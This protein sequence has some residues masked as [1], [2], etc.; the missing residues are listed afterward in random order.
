MIDLGSI[1][2]SSSFISAKTGLAPAYTTALAVAT[3]VILGTITS[4]FFFKF[5]DIKAIC[6]APEQLDVDIAYLLPT[7][8][9][10]F[11]SNFDI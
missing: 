6:I 9:A 2:Q 7:K 3:Q 8:F 5:K 10:N 11:C 4:S 1:V